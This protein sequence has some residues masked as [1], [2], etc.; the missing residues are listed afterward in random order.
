MSVYI[1]LDKFVKLLV[2]TNVLVQVIPVIAVHFLVKK[3]ALVWF[4][5]F[6]FWDPKT[7]PV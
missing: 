5:H 7:V 3:Y 6:S 4:K 2:S 1:Y